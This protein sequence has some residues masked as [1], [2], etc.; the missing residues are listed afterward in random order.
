M[1]T[2]NQHEAKFKDLLYE[3]FQFDNADLDFGIY[4]IMNEKRDVIK[5]FIQEDLP[6]IVAAEM[7]RGEL[8]D[9]THIAEQLENLTAKIEDLLGQD[10]LDG[11]GGLD[12]RYHDS[13]AGRRYLKL[14]AR[15]SGGAS[16]EAWKTD[17][18]ALPRRAISDG[19]G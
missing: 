1:K 18:R 2:K 14:R 11:D 16:R 9:Q 10:S 7:N 19:D 17:P 15:A 4:R 8:A 13:A 3:L 6:D 12:A 5:K